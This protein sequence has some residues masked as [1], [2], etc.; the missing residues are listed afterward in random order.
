MQVDEKALDQVIKQ[1]GTRVDEEYER[2][3]GLHDVVDG[4]D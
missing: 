3:L 2:V 4:E 1:N